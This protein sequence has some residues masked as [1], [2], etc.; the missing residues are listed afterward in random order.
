MPRLKVHMH[1]KVYS[2]VYSIQCI[3]ITQ[4]V[5]QTKWCIRTVKPSSWLLNR[6][7]SSSL[8]MKA[9][10]SIKQVEGTPFTTSIDKNMIP[11]LPH[12]NVRV[13]SNLPK[14]SDIVSMVCLLAQ[15]RHLV[16]TAYRRFLAMADCRPCSGTGTPSAEWLGKDLP[17]PLFLD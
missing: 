2:V 4:Y 16:W 9:Q 17:L 8:Q 1:H 14:Q 6:Y 13:L 12:Q 11:E 10:R 3:C 5:C 7:W 15:L